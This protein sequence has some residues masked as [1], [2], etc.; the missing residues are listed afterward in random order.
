MASISYLVT[1]KIPLLYF[2]SFYRHSQMQIL[3]KMLICTI[4]QRAKISNHKRIVKRQ[5]VD[6]Y[7]VVRYGRVLAL[8]NLYQYLN[9]N[10][11][12]FFTTSFDDF[13]LKPIN[14]TKFLKLPHLHHYFDRS[15]SSVFYFGAI[16][17]MK[18]RKIVAC[19]KE[20]I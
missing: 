1:I 6:C 17:M 4:S 18:I 15:E 13:F 20:L 12:L 7:L 16:F 19:V 11:D 8:P 3:T 2:I 9:Q 5:L 14:W 10:A